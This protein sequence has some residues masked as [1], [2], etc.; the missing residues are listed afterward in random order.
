MCGTKLCPEGLRFAVRDDGDIN[1]VSVG[2]RC[3]A[4]GVVGVYADWKI[5]YSPAQDLPA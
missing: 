1:W 5:D 4:D 3:L 2:L